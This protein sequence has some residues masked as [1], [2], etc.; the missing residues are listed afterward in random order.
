MNM[1]YSLA[2]RHSWEKLAV[3]TTRPAQRDPGADGTGMV[4][5]DHTTASADVAREL[6]GAAKT[7]GLS[8]V[9]APVSVVR[10]ALKTAP[11]L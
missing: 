10:Q 8:F 5:V 6:Y 4:F 2:A 9:D 11:S 7:L 1:H 3:T